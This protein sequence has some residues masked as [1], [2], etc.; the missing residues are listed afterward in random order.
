MSNS[1]DNPNNPYDPRT[2]RGR[3]RLEEKEKTKQMY[4][5]ELNRG[6]NS[7]GNG[8]GG[9]GGCLS[10]CGVIAVLVVIGAIIDIIGSMLPYIAVAAAVVGIWFLVRYVRKKKDGERSATVGTENAER[11][12]TD[13]N[14]NS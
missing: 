3:Q 8:G 2:I 14:K 12:G 11:N 7:G 5:D 13:T 9:C 4:M 1:Y 10:L 6:Q